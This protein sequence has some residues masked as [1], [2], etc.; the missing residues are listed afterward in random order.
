MRDVSRERLADEPQVVLHV[1]KRDGLGRPVDERVA[2][3]GDVD[4]E[5]ARVNGRHRA[6]DRVDEPVIGPRPSRVDHRDATRSQVV[7]YLAEEFAGRQVERDVRLSICV[8]H[9]DVVLAC[10][11]I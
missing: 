7:A 6:R 1:G 3:L 4:E 8:H 2:E 11:R 10:L 5:H 9:D